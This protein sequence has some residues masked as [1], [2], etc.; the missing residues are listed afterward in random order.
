[1]KYTISTE[2]EA[3]MMCLSAIKRAS[4]KLEKIMEDFK[5]QG[6]IDDY[7]LHVHPYNKGYQ[8]S[9]GFTYDLYK[10]F[11]KDVST[12]IFANA[13]IHIQPDTFFESDLSE[14]SAR[15]SYKTIQNSTDS[16]HHTINVSDL[17]DVHNACNQFV[18]SIKL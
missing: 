18:E 8:A 3:Q 16:P 2:V 14:G 5:T 10:V 1:M 7:T 13:G 9:L 6:H 4:E 11:P 12:F 17:G 15:I